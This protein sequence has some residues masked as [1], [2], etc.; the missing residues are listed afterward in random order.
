MLLL[1]ILAILVIIAFGIGF[2]VHW[3]FVIAVIAALIW[4]IS[5]FLGGTRGRSRSTWW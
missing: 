4:L 2:A 1:V 3:L 5:F